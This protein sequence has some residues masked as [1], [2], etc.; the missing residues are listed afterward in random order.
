VPL[1]FRKTV[2]PTRPSFSRDFAGLKT[3]DHGAGPAITFTR[4]SNATFFDATGTLQTAGTNVPRFDHDPA[5]GASRGLL[6]EEARTNSIRNSQAGGANV[7]T[8]TMP[9]NW[10]A[11]SANNVTRDV[12]AIG[13]EDSLSYIDV[14]YH[15]T[16]TT[17][18]QAF[19]NFEDS[20]QVAAANGQV[21]TNSVYVKLQAGSMSNA[22]L[23]VTIFERN[24][25]GANLASGAAGF[26]PTSASLKTQRHVLTRTLNQATVAQLLGSI[27]LS[28]TNGNPIDLTLRIAAPQLEQGAFPTSYIPT[29]TAAATRA[30]DFAR[31]TPISSFYN[32]GEGTLF[33][34]F[35]KFQM[36]ANSKVAMFFDP[37]NTARYGGL[38]ND[39]GTPTTNRFIYQNNAGSTVANISFASAA[40]NTVYRNCGGYASDNFQ[41]AQNG[42]LG[43]ADTSGTPA[44][45]LSH[46]GVGCLASTNGQFFLNG[47]IR[48]VAYWPRR[49]SNTLLQQLTT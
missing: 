46:F 12:V 26:T 4:N 42:T 44:D 15:G 18:S 24:S 40:A 17:S 2:S 37:I 20:A 45:T 14:R 30:A 3:L 28:Y 7:S 5:T 39:P 9:T 13:T 19:L 6:I 29:T 31:V 32:Q 34:E 33:G 47:H 10:G 25:L 49:L 43:T 38:E 35:S 27:R 11:A 36:T 16:P 48:K 1:P 41:A 22:T 8:N 21:W 23:D